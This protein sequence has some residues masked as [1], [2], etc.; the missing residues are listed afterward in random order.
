MKSLKNLIKAP[1]EAR[2]STPEEPQVFQDTEP[3]YSEMQQ[4]AIRDHFLWQQAYELSFAP[5]QY[6]TARPSPSH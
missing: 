2:L 3:A 1:A 4:D 6:L 5:G